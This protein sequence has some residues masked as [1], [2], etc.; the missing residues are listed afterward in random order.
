QCR[1]LP[2][3][4]SLPRARKAVIAALGAWLVCWLSLGGFAQSPPRQVETAGTEY[5]IRVNSDLV[6][7]N[8][9]VRD[10]R[11]NLIRD[12]KQSDFTVLE[13]GQPQQ[14][15]SFDLEDVERFAQSGPAQVKAQAAP[16]AANLLTGSETKPA[17]IRNRRLIVL[18]FDLTNMEPDE[19]NR[20]SQSALHFIDKQMT[21][22]DLVAVVS[23]SSSMQV[24]QDFTSNHDLLSQAVR[25]M[26]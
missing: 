16:Q 18:L 21:P 8:V 15:R 6:L 22:A 26:Q 13:D 24:N 12:M 11:G 14:L 1:M 10:K 19:L 20:A 17:S 23:F 9:S 7:V 2:I 5:R 4:V 25:R 3:P